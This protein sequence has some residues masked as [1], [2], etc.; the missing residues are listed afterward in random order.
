[1]TDDVSYAYSG[2]EPNVRARHDLLKGT[3]VLKVWPWSQEL[4]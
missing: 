4:I 1:M 2:G 3:F